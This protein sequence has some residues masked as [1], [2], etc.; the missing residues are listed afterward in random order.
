M[1]IE[2]KGRYNEVVEKVVKKLVENDLNM[3]LEKCKWK[4]REVEFLEVVIG[5]DGI[6]TEE[7]KIKEVL[8]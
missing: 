2:E 3:K 4:M 8:N 7:K 1:R 5:P 6:K